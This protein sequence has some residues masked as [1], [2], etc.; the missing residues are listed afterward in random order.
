MTRDP[1][2]FSK[3]TREI[4]AKRARQ[5]CSNPGCR[6]STSGPHTDDDKAI[7]V[8]EAAHIRGAKPGSK[9]YD[10]AMTPAER[11][12][13][14]NGIWLC[15]TCAKLIDSDEKKFTVEILYKWKRKHEAE[16]D[17]EAGE[18]N[19]ERKNREANLEPFKKES[20]AAQQIV[21]DQPEGWEYL[22]TLELLR[23]K[24]NQI[25]Q[26]F[27][28]LRRGLIYRPSKVLENHQFHTWLSQKCQELVPMVKLLQIAVSEELHSSWGESGQPG[29]ILKIKRAVDK[30]ISGCSNLL[31]WETDLQ[32][33]RFPN[34][35]E[36]IKQNMQ[37]WTEP[38]LL[39]FDR[40]Q[41]E[42]E[43]ILSDSH[44]GPY[45]ITLVFKL[46]DIDHDILSHLR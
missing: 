10:P 36:R 41:K 38:L 4:L 31:E 14:T 12:A 22:L 15:R 21:L 17:L 29:D 8:G 18:T 24:L 5:L 3:I 16:R 28:D 1:N 9:R 40:L 35:Y 7:D 44:K 23:P 43:K 42:I 27:Y 39:E 30:I 26:E 6:N 32:F 34:K 2:Q 13:I 19:W 37:G 46:P 20:A 11:R 25:K 45:M 33:T